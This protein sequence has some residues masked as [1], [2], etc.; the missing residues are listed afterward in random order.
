MA[1]WRG[2]TATLLRYAPLQAVTF[3]VRDAV[4]P[5]TQL[6]AP[7]QSAFVA[8]GFAGFIATGCVY[9]LDYARLRLAEDVGR[10]RSFTSLRECLVESTKR[11]GIQG[12]YGGVSYAMLLA[13]GYRSLYFGTRILI[14]N[15]EKTFLISEVGM[16]LAR[17]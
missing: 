4:T 13:A 8:G 6:L 15:S 7:R 9:P 17:L 12:I 3:A 11:T 10:T 5:A 2:N 14:V 1:L 16:H